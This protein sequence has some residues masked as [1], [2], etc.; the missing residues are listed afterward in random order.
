MTYIFYILAA[1]FEI[2]GCYA[3]WCFFKLHKTWIYIPLGI[4]FLSIFALCLTRIEMNAT[5][6]IYAT[7]GAIYIIASVLWMCI[8]ERVFPTKIEMLSLSFIMVGVS[9]MLYR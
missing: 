3:F 2:L 7:Y 9:L 5:G 8:F 4:I 1:I 6:K